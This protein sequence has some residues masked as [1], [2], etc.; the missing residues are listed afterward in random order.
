MVFNRTQE[1]DNYFE[2]N[3]EKETTQS[4]TANVTE[5]KKESIKENEKMKDGRVQ[6]SGVNSVVELELNCKAK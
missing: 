5:H 1:R 4:Y 2:Q 3:K 6:C